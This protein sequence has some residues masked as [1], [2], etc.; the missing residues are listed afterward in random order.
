V[1]PLDADIVT[2]CELEFLRNASSIINHQSPRTVQN[3]LVWRFMMIQVDKM[4]NR[5][6]AI[7]QQFN[8][9]FQGI[10]IERARAITCATFVNDN[11]AFAVSKLY[12]KENFKGNARNQVFTRIIDNTNHSLSFSYAY[13]RSK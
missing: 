3:Y 5:F 2:V 4:P 10:S 9:V 12:I 13:S 1:N 11:M 6:R 8:Q 7:N